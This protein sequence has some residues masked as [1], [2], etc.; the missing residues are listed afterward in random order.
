[1]NDIRR[2]IFRFGHKRNMELIGNKIVDI[3]VKRT[4]L[5]NDYKGSKFPPLSD[6]YV[7]L[8]KQYKRDGILHKTTSPSKA[9]NTLT[10]QLLHS[11]GIVKVK[12]GSVWIGATKEDRK[13]VTLKKSKTTNS[14]LI[15]HLENQGRAFFGL[16]E[17]NWKALLRYI[18]KIMKDEI[19]RTRFKP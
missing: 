12:N 5:G 3:I 2:L 15:E 19:R 16:T 7:E 14:E 18:R 9:N 1:M 4:R 11:I 8:R 6:D 13:T 17:L 10:G